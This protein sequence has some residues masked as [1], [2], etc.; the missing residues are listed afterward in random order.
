MTLGEGGHSAAEDISDLGL[1]AEG[2]LRTALA[3]TG[4]VLCGRAIW[5]CITISITGHFNRDGMT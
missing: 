2:C 4:Q 3:G 1:T 5:R